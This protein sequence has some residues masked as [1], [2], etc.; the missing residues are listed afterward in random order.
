MFV[1]LRVGTFKCNQ[2]NGKVILGFFEPTKAQWWSTYVL[3]FTSWLDKIKMV[4]CNEKGCP[5]LHLRSLES[6]YKM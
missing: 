3:R 1:E 4:S 2:A 6:A 5:P